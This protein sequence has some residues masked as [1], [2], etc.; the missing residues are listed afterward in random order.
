MYGTYRSDESLQDLEQV[1]E[2]TGSREVLGEKFVNRSERGGREA[3]SDALRSSGN[4]LRW[5]IGRWMPTGGIRCTWTVWEIKESKWSFNSLN[6]CVVK[7]GVISV[8]K[9]N[10]NRRWNSWKEEEKIWLHG[11]VRLCSCTWGGRR[12]DRW[13]R[14]LAVVGWLLCFGLVGLVGS[15]Q[16][17]F[18]ILFYFL[19][20]LLE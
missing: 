13:P 20:Y 3:Q 11:C 10:A 19:F 8:L 12:P 5:E 1:V 14:S 16:S 18:L 9:L 7:W 17:I 4:G 6:W 15:A 2:G